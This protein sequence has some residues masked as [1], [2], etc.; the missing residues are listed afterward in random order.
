MANSRSSSYS[1]LW[2]NAGLAQLIGICVPEDEMAHP[3]PYFDARNIT[4]GTSFGVYNPTGLNGAGYAPQVLGAAEHDGIR[5]SS[6][7]GDWRR[8]ATGTN[9]LDNPV[10]TGFCAFNADPIQIQSLWPSFTGSDASQGETLT[11]CNPSSFSASDI[12]DS[13]G[14]QDNSAAH[15]RAGAETARLGWAMQEATWRAPVGDDQR[16]EVAAL[17][18][19]MAVASAAPRVAGAGADSR[20]WSPSTAIRLPTASSPPGRKR[21]AGGDDAEGGRQAGLEEFSLGSGLP[22]Q[23]SIRHKRSR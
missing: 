18:D 9:P 1:L 13:V 12:S 10:S 14:A 20:E 3:S 19:C 4:R 6:L 11:S 7:Q 16:I 8:I 22:S 2:P 21:R 5:E 17:H 15:T 23:S